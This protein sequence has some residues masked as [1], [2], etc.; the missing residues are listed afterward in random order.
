MTALTSA[1]LSSASAPVLDE[2]V[3]GIQLPEDFDDVALAC[4]VSEDALDEVRARSIRIMGHRRRDAAQTFAFG[5]DLVFVQQQMRGEDVF[6]DFASETFG[7]GEKYIVKFMRISTEL[8]ADR[9]RCIANSMSST[10]LIE[11][12]PRTPQERD[13][14]LTK[15]EQGQKVTAAQIKNWG[16]EE[17]APVN[18]L[19]QSGRKGLM[20]VGQS[21]LKS[22]VSAFTM[23]VGKVLARI[24]SDL[25]PEKGKPK[26]IQK[27][28]LSQDVRAD[29]RTAFGHLE[30]VACGLKSNAFGD[31]VPA[32]L[33]EGSGW[34]KVKDLV[35]LLG[36][37]DNEWPNRGALRSWLD[38]EVVPTLRWALGDGE[39][40]ETE[41]RPTPSIDV[42]DAKVMP[43]AR[44]LVDDEDAIETATPAAVIETAVAAPEAVGP[45]KRSGKASPAK[46]MRSSLVDVPLAADDLPSALAPAANRESPRP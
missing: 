10:Q 5:D 12:L 2:S 14:I 19:V 6:A 35:Y 29:A 23:L 28:K 3:L 30:R 39:A 25:E 44:D 41:V 33:P 36:R 34:R 45:K 21:N 8:A 40:V 7:Y 1:L 4:G 9:Y 32:D 42:E 37:P 11:M 31:T 26:A 43:A 27:G 38:D 17:E 18:P 15:L 13:E 16:K 46:A 24:L 22:G 20:A